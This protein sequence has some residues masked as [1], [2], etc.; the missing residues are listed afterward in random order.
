MLT[1]RE[2]RLIYDPYFK[3][4]RQTNFFIEFISIN[5]NHCWIIKKSQLNSNRLII[6]YHKHSQNLPYYHKQCDIQ[7]VILA[8]KKIKAH[9]NYVICN[10][11]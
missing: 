8:I 7:N 6:L 3:I 1:K 11:Y 2:C 5:T 4:I 9:D 10:H